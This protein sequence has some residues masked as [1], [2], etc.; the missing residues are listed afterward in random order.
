MPEDQEPSRLTVD[1]QEATPEEDEFFSVMEQM[2]SASK[3][4][5]T[6]APKASFHD[7]WASGHKKSK[8]SV[9]NG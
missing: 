5:S 8:H 4:A 3:T 6:K 1:I 7:P 9:R 2:A